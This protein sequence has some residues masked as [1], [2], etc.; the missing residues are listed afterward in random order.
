MSSGPSY[1]G[2]LNSITIRRTAMVSKKV[3]GS[4]VLFSVMIALM[5]VPMYAQQSSLLRKVHSITLQNRGTLMRFA[6]GGIQRF[7]HIGLKESG[8]GAQITVYDLPDMNPVDTIDGGFTILGFSRDGEYI[9]SGKVVELNK[10]SVS[11]WKIGENSRV[12]PDQ[13]SVRTLFTVV[14]AGI[15]GDVE[16][17]P[18]GSTI[19]VGGHT[20]IRIVDVHSE[21]PVLID[22]LVV[23]NNK[24]DTIYGIVYDVAVDNSGSRIIG[25]DPLRSPVMWD[26][27]TRQ[28]IWE[29][30]SDGWKTF[31]VQWAADDS[32]LLTASRQNDP[33]NSRM[34]FRDPQNGQVL[35]SYEIPQE[36]NLYGVF[37]GINEQYIV[38]RTDDHYIR[39]FDAT[40]FE[41]VDAFQPYGGAFNMTVSSDG[42][43]VATTDQ[44]NPATTNIYEFI[45]SSVSAPV[46]GSSDQHIHLFAPVP[47]PA[48]GSINLSFDVNA[49]SLVQL[50]LYDLQGR[51]VL[52]L[53]SRQYEAGRF[54]EHADIGSL[55]SG[56]YH[57]VLEATEGSVWQPLQIVH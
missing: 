31:S 43:Y 22:T 25:V 39:I 19:Y 17:S 35:R 56:L 46:A 3:F 42:R 57:V 41:L 23:W 21:P 11:S 48:A 29:A 40:N 12:I 14:P 55:P 45:T 27:V 8:F 33:N 5:V 4:G 20:G 49:A 32:R 44:E 16:S 7:A 34:E 36:Y 2:K 37:F 24:A 9:I 38:T 53:G 47:N 28:R 52:D 50:A 10:V 54:V 26:A 51:R 6:T 13:D 15:L 30:P 1:F 18:D